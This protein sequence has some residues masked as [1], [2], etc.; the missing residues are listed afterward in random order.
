M[1]FDKAVTVGE[2]NN[3]RAE[4]PEAYGGSGTEPLTR[5]FSFFQKN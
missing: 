5:I 2:S 3:A 4:P 1:N